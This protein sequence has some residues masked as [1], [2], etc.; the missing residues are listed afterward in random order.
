LC[1]AA[2]VWRTLG[3]PWIRRLSSRQPPISAGCSYLG[4]TPGLQTTTTSHFNIIMLGSLPG[5]QTA[6]RHSLRRTG[7]SYAV[8]GVQFGRD[9]F[10]FNI[11]HIRQAELR[12]IGSMRALNTKGTITKRPHSSQ[13]TVFSQVLS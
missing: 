5:N 3:A 4:P 13:K 10:G 12:F 1:P 11:A 6:L 2:N 8:F 7:Q 9:N